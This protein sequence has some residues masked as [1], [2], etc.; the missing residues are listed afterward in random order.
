MSRNPARVK[1]PETLEPILNQTPISHRLA[2]NF[3]VPV[4]HSRTKSFAYIMASKGK[5]HNVPPA[6][7]KAASRGE[8]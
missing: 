1:M 3:T 8:T 4:S 6:L 2:R 5:T 7:L